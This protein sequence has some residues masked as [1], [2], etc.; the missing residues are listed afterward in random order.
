MRFRN[1]Y[2]F[3][4]NMYECDIRM[5]LNGAFHTFT[6]TEAAFQA[7][8]CPSRADEFT[9]ISGRESKRLGQR[10]NLRAD[11]E[12]V[13]IRIMAECLEAKFVQHPAL[14]RRLLAVEGP[15]VEDNTWGDKFWGR[16]NGVGE[17]WLG[18]LLEE[19]RNHPASCGYTADKWVMNLGVE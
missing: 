8:K 11:W 15:I 1:E 4:S 18:R 10:V 19:I 13:K 17:N 6:C 16:C 5:P 2:Y 12:K 7:H 9:G 14:E 3:M